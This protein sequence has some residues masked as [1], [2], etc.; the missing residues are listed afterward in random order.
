VGEPLKRRVGF[1][2]IQMAKFISL[3]L[4]FFGSFLVASAQQPTSSELSDVDK[5]AIVESVLD[6]ER[7][8][9]DF[10]YFRNVSSE[11]IQFMATA[12]VSKHGFTLVASNQF[13]ER[14]ASG[15][16]QFL[17]FKRFSLRDGVVVI[18]LSRVTESES[19]FG[20]HIHSELS[21]TYEARLT[22]KGWVAELTR[23]P[24]PDFF[25]VRKRLNR[26]VPDFFAARKRLNTLR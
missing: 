7:H 6:V 9:L 1:L 2:L 19:W 5:A 21:Y 23:R 17:V 15:V 20:G 26:P 18:A 11:N 25:T 12:Q 22:A 8:N 24:I 3:S 16:E 13:S 4:L 10:G 14:Q